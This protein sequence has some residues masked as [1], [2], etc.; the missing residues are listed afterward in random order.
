MPAPLPI[1]Y[2]MDAFWCGDTVGGT[3]GQVLQLLTH[4]DRRRFDPHLA[5]FRPTPYTERPN[6][7]PC[8]VHVL[9][10]GSLSKPDAAAKLLKLASFVRARRIALAHIFLNDAA[11]VAPLFCRL[12]G[13]QVVASRRDMGFWYTA[14]K[15]RAL[16]VSNRF[17]ARLVANSEAVRRNVHIHERYP[18]DRIEV[19]YNGHDLSRFDVKPCAALR[20]R[21]GIAHGDPIVGMVANFNP[22]KRHLDLV[23][24][25]AAVRRDHATAHLVLVGTGDTEPCRAAVRELG[26]E[27][28]VHFVGGIA[29]AVP[30]IRHFDVGVLCSES[31][32]LSNAVIEYMGA[33]KPTVCTNVGGNP[34][35]VR[36]GH[37]GFLVAPGDISTL[38]NRIS[39][40][41]SNPVLAAA[42]GREARR[43]AEGLTV[44]RMTESYMDL[45]RRLAS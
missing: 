2:I 42:M 35:V 40:V 8:P 10:I 1:L 29:D 15:L 12:A 5:V 22:W 18:A 28:A 24:A 45:Y 34:E 31:E 33:G 27:R 7:L 14:G 21:F 11:I 30:V 13:A 38:A 39:G 43:A 16:R 6:A 19:C 36:D 9:Q 26:L 32:G 20:A 17:V 25:F 3:E 23:Q 41:L 44:Q 37:S 4:L